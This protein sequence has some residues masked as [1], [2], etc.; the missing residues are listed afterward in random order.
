[1]A[2][3]PEQTG[4]RDQSLADNRA[5][6]GIHRGQRPKRIVLEQEIRISE[7][8]TKNVER[9]REVR[10]AAGCRYLNAEDR[11]RIVAGVKGGDQGFQFLPIDGEGFRSTDCLKAAVKAFVICAKGK[12]RVRIEIPFDCG[13]EVPRL[14]RIGERIACC[15]GCT[16]SIVHR[17]YVGDAVTIGIAV[18]LDDEIFGPSHRGPR[19][20]AVLIIIDTDARIG[21]IVQ[22]VVHRIAD[23]GFLLGIGLLVPRK[24]QRDTP[25]ATSD[26]ELVD[27]TAGRPITQVLKTLVFVDVEVLWV[28]VQLQLALD[29]A[30]SVI[31]RPD[32]LE[33]YLARD[34]AF[35]QT[36]RLRL[37]D[38]HGAEQFR[39]KLVLL[40][41]RIH[42]RTIRSVTATTRSTSK[43][44]LTTSAPPDSRKVSGTPAV[45]EQATG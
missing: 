42:V 8:V 44:G 1:M 7:V 41:C 11:R 19:R 37:V 28:V 14:E 20:I 13:V 43:Q 35:D 32:A 5:A 36:G 34:T 18:L 45:P 24:S 16:N 39:W 22:A 31:E 15:V 2:G 9:A 27:K 26:I 17:K 30:A 23:I 10:Q 33:A 38:P 21:R 3:E 29:A 12:D 6:V 40:A 4:R 25:A